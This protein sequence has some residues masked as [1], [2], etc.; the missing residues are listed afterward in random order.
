MCFLIVVI[1]VLPFFG[2]LSLAVAE[3][4]SLV[5]KFQENN[6]ALSMD[7]VKNIPLVGGLE[8]IP[9]KIDYESLLNSSQVAS[10]AQSATGLVF[11]LAK[12]AYES[13]S[14]FVFM[15]AVMFFSLYYFF[16]D[17]DAFLR[18]IMNLSPLSTKQEKKLMERFERISKATIKGTLVIALIQ[19]LLMGLTFWIAGVSAPVLWAMVTVV[20]SIIPLLGAVLVWLPVGIVMLLLGNVWQAMVIFIIGAI[21]VSS[22]D[23][24]L[25]PKLVEGQSSMHPLL[26]FLSTLGG[27]G[28]FGAAGFIVGPVVISLLLALLEIYQEQFKK[29]LEACNNP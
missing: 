19:G 23:N 6:I 2:V 13:T 4:N 10:G 24:L 18:R 20:I 1:I 7:A 21:V 29:D 17:G 11:G 15:M 22:V 9:K 16:K 8:F 12:K 27:I 5:Q 3:T 26:V 25:R 14:G 28:L